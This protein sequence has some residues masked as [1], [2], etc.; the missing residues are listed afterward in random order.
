MGRQIAKMFST[1]SLW[2][3]LFL[4]I[5]SKKYGPPHKQTVPPICKNDKNK[6][7]LQG[8]TGLKMLSRDRKQLSH[9]VNN[10]IRRW[11]SPNLMNQEKWK[12]WHLVG[13]ENFSPLFFTKENSSA[14][15]DSALCYQVLT[16]TGRFFIFIVEQSDST[17]FDLVDICL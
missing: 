12:Q 9:S 10:Y 8:V 13:T 5:W 1:S 16:M 2:G 4:V 3:S 15:W 14:I 11:H 17:R 6:H 7:L